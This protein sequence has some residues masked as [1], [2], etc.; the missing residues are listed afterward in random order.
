MPLLM[1][2]GKTYSCRNQQSTGNT[3]ASVQTERGTMHDIA[4][5]VADTGAGAIGRKPLVSRCARTTSVEATEGRSCRDGRPAH[6]QRYLMRERHG[7]R[8]RGGQVGVAGIRGTV[9]SCVC[10]RE[11]REEEGKRQE[12]TGEKVDAA[13][14]RG[15]V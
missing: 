2:P 10:V 3:C 15:T 12:S 6:T 7:R 8:V 11:D 5:E 14:I 13:G 1:V 9:S 4:Q